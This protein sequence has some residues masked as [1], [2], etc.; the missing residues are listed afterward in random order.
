MRARILVVD[1][2]EVLCRLFTERL[3]LE[4]FQVT[5][6]RSGREAL[7]LLEQEPRDLIVLDL[8]MPGMNGLDILRR[9]RERAWEV[10]VV[11]L[12]AYGT[13][14]R[15]REALALGVREFIGKPFDLDRL[16]RIVAVEFERRLSIVAVE[17]ERRRP[18]LAG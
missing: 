3:R 13:V 5:T 8:D 11:V 7:A 16:L 18:R 4:G 15:A 2:E 1:D 6:A 10:K 17:F 14:Q 12:T 9:I